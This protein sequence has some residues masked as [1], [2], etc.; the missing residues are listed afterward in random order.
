M[1]K[2][3]IQLSV[4]RESLNVKG[5]GGRALDSPTFHSSRFTVLGSEARTKLADFFSIL[6]GGP[7]PSV[8][9]A[10][11]KTSCCHARRK[12][13]TDYP[14]RRE[15]RFPQFTTPKFP[16]QIRHMGFRPEP[17]IL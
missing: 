2:K 12:H 4:R 15:A 16:T 1:L 10:H 13:H 17:F 11:S 8:E 14:T 5:F 3:A 6:L 7:R 9:K